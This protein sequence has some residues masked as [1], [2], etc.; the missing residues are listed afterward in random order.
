MGS[1]VAMVGLMGGAHWQL[2][3]R[4]YPSQ[5]SSS[6]PFSRSSSERESV[7][8]PGIQKQQSHMANPRDNLFYFFN[9]GCWGAKRLWLDFC[10]RNSHRLDT[11][12]V[13][14]PGLVKKWERP[15]V[16]CSFDRC[17]VVHLT[18]YL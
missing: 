9:L 4:H 13:L 17:L 11:Y 16:F 15:V 1:A 8:L 10:F 14:P 18:H 5:R 3:P 12:T 2:L 7:S 6:E